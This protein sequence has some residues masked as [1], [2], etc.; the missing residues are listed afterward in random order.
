M[1]YGL[2]QGVVSVAAF[3][4]LNILVLFTVRKL[5]DLFFKCAARILGSLADVLRPKCKA[6][7][8]FANSEMEAWSTPHI[9]FIALF[10]AVGLIL[11]IP[12]VRG[13]LSLIGL[14]FALLVYPFLACALSISLL[15]KL[16]SVKS[17]WNDPSGK[18]I[19]FGGQIFVLFV[20][21]GA[22][23]NW[24]AEMWKVSPVNF[25]LTHATATGFMM[26]ACLALLMMAFALVFELLFCFSLMASRDLPK[27]S[28]GEDSITWYLSGIANS[29]MEGRVARN[30]RLQG[31]G[32]VV[33][34]LTT[35]VAC[36]IAVYAAFALSG[37]RVANTFL[38]AVAFELDAVP[39]DRC[40]LATNDRK[41]LAKKDPDVKVVFLA[42]SQ[43][44]A[45]VVRRLKDFYKP[46]VLRKFNQDPD[47]IKRSILVGEAV[48]C[49]VLK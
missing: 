44:K 8:S 21:K 25:P 5:L 38:A 36:V 48:N 20:A 1:V 29:G 2:V 39:G 22:A 7:I 47:A 42:T 23:N 43:E 28:T 18:I 16:P 19:F 4:T 40:E 27:A 9:W 15:A 34:T 45:L 24:L 33:V 37:T 3:L 31:A 46:M 49:Y 30:L 14:V 10:Q 17:C 11:F 32:L 41:Q 6:I 13:E 12:A 35:F 26:L